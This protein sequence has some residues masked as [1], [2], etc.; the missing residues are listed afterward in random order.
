MAEKRKKN[1]RGLVLKW[2]Y[3]A[4]DSYAYSSALSRRHQVETTTHF[5]YF[6]PFVISSYFFNEKREQIMHKHTHSLTKAQAINII[7]RFYIN[8]N[9]AHK[10]IQ[11]KSNNPRLTEHNKIFDC[12]KVI[13]DSQTVM[14]INQ[15]KKL[16]AYWQ[17]FPSRKCYERDYAIAV[18]MLTG[19]WTPPQRYIKPVYC[20]RYCR[21]KCSDVSICDYCAKLLMRKVA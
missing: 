15:A 14:S 2:L 12:I 10:I 19:K 16:Y 4:H 18:L 11:R 1:F 21:T 13:T 6:Y 7:G 20:C 9:L 8:P 5:I 3:C 17:N